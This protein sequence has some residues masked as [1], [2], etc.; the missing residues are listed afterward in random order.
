VAALANAPG[1]LDF[2][3]WLVWKSWSLRKRTARIPLFGCEGLTEQLGKR[4][5][6]RRAHFQTNHLAV[7][8]NRPSTLTPVPGKHISRRVRARRPPITKS[9]RRLFQ[10][11]KRL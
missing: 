9:F 8:Q 11:R 5:V 10:V 2:Y 1:A 3:V 7:A 6:R 4:S